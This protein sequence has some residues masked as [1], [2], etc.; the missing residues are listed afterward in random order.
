MQ[1]AYCSGIGMYF[2]PRTH[3]GPRIVRPYGEQ[4]EKA[5]VT[6]KPRAVQSSSSSHWVSC[7]RF[8]CAILS[9]KRQQMPLVAAYAIRG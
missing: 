1:A 6:A 5:S 4:R 9:V 2:V 7:G 8:G 3:C